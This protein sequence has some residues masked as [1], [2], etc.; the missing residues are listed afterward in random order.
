MI[1]FPGL[2]SH[3]RGF[4]PRDVVSAVY[5]MATWLDS[6]LAGW[7]GVCHSL[8]CIKTAK[9][10]LKLFPP[11]GS[12]II[13]VSSD[14]YPISRGTPSVRA[15]NTHGVGK[16]GDFRRKSPFISETVR[17]RPMVTMER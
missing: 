9:N 6:W 12:S 5:A 13:L 11:S 10:I 1:R 3:A 4:Y 16:I 7:V 2:Q 15:L 8:Y 14:R 17:D